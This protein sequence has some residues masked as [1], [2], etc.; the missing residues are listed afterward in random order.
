MPQMVKKDAADAQ[1][2]GVTLQDAAARISAMMDGNADVNPKGTKS[3]LTDP[4]GRDLKGRFRATQPADEGDDTADAEDTRARKSVD[5]EADDTADAEDRAQLD[6]DTP[7]TADDEESDA[8]PPIQTLA[9]LAEALDIPLAELKKQLK[10]TFKAAGTDVTATLDELESGYQKE[11]DY[12]RSKTKLSEERRTFENAARQQAEKF[13]A[14][15]HVLAQQYAVAEQLLSAEAQHPR[16]EQLR[17]SDPAEWTARINELQQRMQ[18]LGQARYT[19]AAHYDNFVKTQTAELRARESARLAEVVPDWDDT[20]RV[21]AR[22]VIGSFGFSEDE[23]STVYDA[24]LIKGALELAALRDEVA[25]LR[26]EKAKSL[27]TSTRIKKEVP[28]LQKP[29]KSANQ[30]AGGLRKENVNKLR[31]RLRSSGSIRDAASL[32]ET[33]L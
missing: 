11:V 30:S 21:T 17:M 7:D 14:N 1:P 28:K 26:A 33:M 5:D 8:A 2:Q 31:Q 20:K 10:H 13:V 4:E 32:I 25:V 18:Q 12:Q 23:L 27:E 3:R 6:E 24:R 19:A 16:M 9:E 15:S 29:G 22:N